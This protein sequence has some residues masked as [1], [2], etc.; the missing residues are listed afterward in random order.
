[1]D[2]IDNHSTQQEIPG[3]HEED[4]AN[5]KPSRFKCNPDFKKIIA[6]MI[7]FNLNFIF[8]Q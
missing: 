8:K 7:T 6:F 2:D 4:A 3:E 5:K 1:M